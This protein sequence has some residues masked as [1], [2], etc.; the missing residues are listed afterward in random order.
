MKTV[1]YFFCTPVGVYLAYREDGI[2]GADLLFGRDVALAA[3]EE[4]RPGA[5]EPFRAFAEAV[6]PLPGFGLPPQGERRPVPP[7]YVP[8]LS[9]LF[10]MGQDPGIPEEKLASVVHRPKTCTVFVPSRVP[11]PGVP[12]ACGF[13]V[14]IDA[15]RKPTVVGFVSK[16]HA[17]LEMRKRRWDRYRTTEMVMAKIRGCPLPD[18][19]PIDLFELSGPFGRAVADHFHASA[20][21]FF[22]W[23][24]RA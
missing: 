17:G 4:A 18:R 10:R 19:G 11:P 8:F 9:S 23:K 20:Q 24:R 12:Y 15:E 6:S 21:A 14:G 1:T 22:A 7:V 16:E 3:V 13:L 5:G 2:D